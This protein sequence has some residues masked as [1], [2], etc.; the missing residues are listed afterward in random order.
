MLA[1]VEVAVY[2]WV[3]LERDIRT[4]ERMATSIDWIRR[5]V[6]SAQPCIV[7][8]ADSDASRC[9]ISRLYLGDGAGIQ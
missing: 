8:C 1:E 5:W 2:T 3:R 9:V 7:W 6:K 4:R